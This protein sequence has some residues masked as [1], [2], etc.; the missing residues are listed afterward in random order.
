VTSTVIPWLN[1]QIA[2]L[3]RERDELHRLYAEA[4]ARGDDERREAE[5]ELRAEVEREKEDNRRLRISLADAHDKLRQYLRD[6]TLAA[7]KLETAQ[8]QAERLRAALKQIASAVFYAKQ[9]PVEAKNLQDMAREA[10]ADPVP[11]H[12]HA[13]S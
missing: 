13:A 2:D 4:L 5:D 6:Q 1:S 12:H 3:T 9:T 10:L 8:L 11:A 7:V